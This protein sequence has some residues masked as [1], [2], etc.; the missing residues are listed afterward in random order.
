[1]GGLWTD[2]TKYSIWL[3][4]ELCAGEG[5]AQI[6]RIPKI[7]A[8]RMRKNARFDPRRIAKIEEKTRHDVVAFVANVGE[9]L[10]KDAGYFHFGLTSSDVLDTALAV[11][12][13]RAGQLI[14]EQFK[15]PKQLLRRLAKKYRRTPIAGRSHGVFAEPTALGL[16]FALWYTDLMRSERRLQT[17]FENVAVGKISG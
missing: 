17:A 5:W 13:S 8:K 16:K 10:G 15:P 14:L 1:M 11:Q 7:A 4:V 6:G 9:S 3:E 12:L 2:A